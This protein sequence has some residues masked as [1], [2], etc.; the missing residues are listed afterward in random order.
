MFGEVSLSTNYTKYL[1]KSAS[2]VTQQCFS[3]Q[4][5]LVF[6]NRTPKKLLYIYILFTPR[7]FAPHIFC[8]SLQGEETSR[9]LQYC[10][11]FMQNL[12]THPLRLKSLVQSGIYFSA[13]WFRLSNIQKTKQ[14]FHLIAHESC[15]TRRGKSVRLWQIDVAFLK[16]IH[17]VESNRLSGNDE[18]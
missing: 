9:Q 14:N 15:K 17:I 8:L 13:E 7:R 18:Y 12:Q 2:F 10:L 11:Q 6:Q 4:L 3:M 16:A 1:H 5:K